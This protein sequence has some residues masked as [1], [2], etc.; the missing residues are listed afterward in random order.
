MA[1]NEWR[2]TNSNVVT[3]GSNVT[4][5][6]G[7]QRELHSVCL[8]VAQCNLEEAEL[9]QETAAIKKELANLQVKASKLQIIKLK[10]ELG[11]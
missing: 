9:K 1:S 7:Q 2:F 11:K 4:Q 8:Q 3:G 5:S 10:K 6:I